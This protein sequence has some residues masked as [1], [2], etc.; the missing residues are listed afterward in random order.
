MADL[1]NSAI[2]ATDKD[3]LSLRDDPRFQEQRQY[4]EGLWQRYKPY[5]DAN[6]GGEIARQFHSR[7]WEMYLACTLMDQEHDLIRTRGGPDI[8]IKNGDGPIWVEATAPSRGEGPDALPE[9][10]IRV[11]SRPMAIRI[12]ENDIILRFRSALEGKLRKYLE[13][14]RKGKIACG[15]PFVKN[16]LDETAGTLWGLNPRGWAG[17]AHRRRWGGEARTP[18]GEGKGSGR[19]C[20]DRQPEGDTRDDPGKGF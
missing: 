11:G 1:L 5:A 14:R 3:Y 4:F 12:P 6:F 2:A 17:G 20:R 16:L 19:G 7:F 8:C 13:Y 10:E 15:E 18:G 9:P